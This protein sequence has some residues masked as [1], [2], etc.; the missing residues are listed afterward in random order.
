MNSFTGSFLLPVPP[1]TPSCPPLGGAAL[2]PAM[3]LHAP[4]LRVRPTPPRPPRPSMPR[5]NT[6]PPAPLHSTPL[7][8]PPRPS[9]SLSSPGGA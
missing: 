8:A 4:S 7:H 2:G 6:P 5:P 1:G 3:R 9:P